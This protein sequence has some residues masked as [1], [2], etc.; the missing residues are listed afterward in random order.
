[1]SISVKNISK[2]YGE[3]KALNTISFEINKG[4]IV[5]FLGPN[6]AGK[7]TMMKILTGYLSLTDGEAAICGLDV[8]ENAQAIKS[9]IGY[10]P[11]HNPL[12]HDM[13]I[14]EYLTF[15][16]KV[17]GMDNV[18]ERVAK[19]I[20]MVGLTPEQSKKIG[21]LSKGYRQRVGLA[22]ALIHEP[23]V[24]ILDEPTTGLD[25]NQI[26]EIRE[27][28]KNVG[29]DKTVMLS[30]HIMQ[31]VQAICSRAIIINKGEIVADNSV[32]NITKDDKD[33]TKVLA[34]SFEKHLDEKMIR[35]ISGVTKVQSVEGNQFLVEYTV[36]SNPRKALMQLS[37][38]ND[39]GINHLQDKEK[40][41]EE[42]FK[43]LT[44]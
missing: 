4:E 1:M 32:E 28:I 15:V 36:G 34:V 33:E 30:T 27:L 7:S 37:L 8:S 31:E 13:Y 29:Q 44:N 14:K 19:M 16:A 38:D 18:K 2:I 5:G 22:Q 3:Q 12:Y 11:E 20:E 40:S 6:G 9:K 25:P 24:L 41:L 39:N 21:D 43:E 42:L 23:E 35:S 17:Y 10:L 26:V